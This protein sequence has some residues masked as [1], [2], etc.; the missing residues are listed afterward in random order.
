MKVSSMELSRLDRQI[1]RNHRLCHQSA[2]GQ[3]G[4][5][6]GQPLMLM[7]IQDHQPLYQ[8]DLASHMNVTPASVTVSLKRMEKNGWLTR[9]ADREDQ[10][11]TAIRLTP[12]GEELACRCKE[13]IDKID[14]ERYV[15]FSEEE[16]AQLADF[17]RRM[18][19][20]LQA[21]KQRGE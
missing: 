18:N 3:L 2:M 21:L 9:I 6:Y 10:R 17:Y 5:H 20:N 8:K 1:H 7:I 19:A 4:L 11:C 15:G 12:K 14:R 16:M 13:E